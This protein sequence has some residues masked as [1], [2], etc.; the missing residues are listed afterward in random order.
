MAIEIEIEPLPKPIEIEIEKPMQIEP[1]A[2]GS[3]KMLVRME[4]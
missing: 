3:G 1:P 4:M 2:F